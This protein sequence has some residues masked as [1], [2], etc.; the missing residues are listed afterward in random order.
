[1]DKCWGSGWRCHVEDNCRRGRKD[2]QRITAGVDGE[3]TAQR[4]TAGMLVH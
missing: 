1:M 2:R 4:T 3:R